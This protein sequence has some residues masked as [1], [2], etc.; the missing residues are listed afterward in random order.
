M[1]LQ[2]EAIS[3]F[4]LLTEVAFFGSLGTLGA[5]PTAALIAGVEMVLDMG[6][7]SLLTLL[8]L[9]AELLEALLLASTQWSVSRL[10]LES[11]ELE[12]EVAPLADA[13]DEAATE[14]VLPLLAAA[15][16]AARAFSSKLLC[17]STISSLT[18]LSSCS[19]NC[20]S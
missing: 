12:L 13:R 15:T 4:T 20:L 6:F 11:T 17:F 14:L 8:L 7:R 10:P 1:F 19:S 16:A 2:D 18:L 5:A 9:L 3:F